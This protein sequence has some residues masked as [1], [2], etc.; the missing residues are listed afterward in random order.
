MKNKLSLNMN[1]NIHLSKRDQKL[2]LILLGLIVLLLCYMLIYRPTIAET[3]TVQGEISALEPTAAELRECYSQ[4]EVYA[5][6]IEEA[7]AVIAQQLK[8][9][10]TDVR[11]EDLIMYVTALE[12]DIGMDVTSI[13]FS[14]D[15]VIAVFD[16]VAEDENGAAVAK[17]Y[18]ASQLSMTVTCSLSYQAL[19]DMA[20]YIAAT[21][22]RTALDSVSLSFSSETGE[23]IGSAT[24]DKYYVSAGDEGYTATDV[25]DVE[26]GTD[27]LFSTVTQA[28]EEAAPEE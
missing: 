6:G 28:D 14:G 19:K 17:S 27:D 11:A 2:I 13:A 5:A 21:P 4:L 3:E 10:P 18:S 12:E 7:R 26:L 9:Y 25:P 16:G 8:Q 1:L 22:L 15:S 23:L 24:I 20:D